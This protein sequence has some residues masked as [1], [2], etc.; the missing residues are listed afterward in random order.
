MPP[1]LL[2]AD[3]IPATI[4]SGVIGAAAVMLCWWLGSRWPGGG[5]WAG[6]VSGFF[7]AVSPWAIS[8]SRKIWQVTF[9]PLLVLAFV[10]LTVSGLVQGRHWR[11][12]WALVV[13]ALLVQV[14]P[15]AISLAPALA[16]WLVLFWRNV[17]LGPLLVGCLTGALTA[18]PFVN[19]QISSGWP[20]IAALHTATQPQTDLSAIALAWDIVTGVGI[21]SLAGASFPQLTAVPELSGAF[22][23][24]GWLV[25]LAVGLLTWRSARRWRALDPTQRAAVRVDLVLI[26]WLLVPVVFN[27]RHTLPLYHHFFLLIAPAAYLILGRAVQTLHDFGKS[28]I[29]RTATLLFLTLLLAGQV[30]VI[31]LMG[32]FIASHDTTGGF[33]I[34]LRDYQA[35]AD[36]AVQRARESNAS[37]ILV[38]GLG[39][40]PVVDEVAAVF[41]IMFRDRIAY[42]FADGQSAAIFPQ[43]AA[44]AV[45]AP[46]AEAAV[47]WYEPSLENGP[48][49]GYRVAELAASAFGDSRVPARPLWMNKP[50]AVQPVTGPRLFENG[51]EL[52]GFAWRD[53]GVPAGRGELWLLWQVLWLDGRDTHFFVQLL[54]DQGAILLQ[55]D[56]AGPPAEVRRKGD[57]VVMKFDIM[58]PGSIPAAPLWGR[59]GLYRYPELDRLPVIDNLGKPVAES[60]LFGPVIER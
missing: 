55:Q 44:V 23:I 8:F 3:P 59:A 1:F 54:D 37:E 29:L 32:R 10:G 12:A 14:H 28:P 43:Q 46:G 22:H 57:R 40:S 16:L 6:A 30:A 5:P 7:F 47:S 60:V 26:S 49:A 58:K 27:L 24:I 42:R 35:I 20:V 52:Q 41:D 56:A 45:L 4:Y 31:V 50:W 15:S 19:H 48:A 34:P 38:F 2:T 13:F 21:H 17:R 25:I 36:D 53:W 18:L 33:G 39:D 9:V 51:L 11:L